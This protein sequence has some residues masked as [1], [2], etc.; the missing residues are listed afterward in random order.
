MRLTDD[1][2]RQGLNHEDREVR[3]WALKYFGWSHSPDARIASEAILAVDRRGIDDAFSTLYPLS[4]LKQTDETIAWAIGR[5]SDIPPGESIWERAR[6]LGFL[7]ARA[8]PALLMPHRNRIASLASLPRKIARRIERTLD[9]STWSADRLWQRL[10]EVWQLG[11]KKFDRRDFP[12]VEA[13]EITTIL[14]RDP[15]NAPLMMELFRLKANEKKGT[16]WRERFMIRLAGE[17]RYE[18]AV[19]AIVYK[20]RRDPLWLGAQAPRALIKI[21]TDSVVEEVAKAYL[22]GDDE[23]RSGAADVFTSI[24]SERAV[25]APIRLIKKER[26]PLNRE[27]LIFALANQPSPAAFDRVCDHIAVEDSASCFQLKSDLIPIIKLMVPDFPQ[28][29]AWEDEIADP[30]AWERKM[31]EEDG[32]GGDYD[33]DDYEDDDA[34]DDDLGGDGPRKK[35]SSFGIVAEDGDADLDEELSEPEDF[36][37]DPD[38]MDDWAAPEKLTRGAPVGRNDPCPC[39]S[40]KKYKKCCLRE[41]GST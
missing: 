40:G 12:F 16:H 30:A 28:L 15:A 31:A 20:W 17:L 18:P 22:R 25:D 36:G 37:A 35:S 19:P 1:E 2:I 41:K 29:K 23:F 26:D 14:G 39:G 7:L 32:L 21:G 8:D 5:L 24:R 13:R 34:G 6:P 4:N 9:F 10:D 27:W 33:G 38:P 11:R 3:T